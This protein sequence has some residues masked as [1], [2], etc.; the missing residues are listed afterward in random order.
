MTRAEQPRSE[1]DGSR[2]D[3]DAE[4][5]HVVNAARVLML[6]KDGPRDDYYRQTKEHAWNV[7]RDALKALDRR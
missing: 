5:D 6:L 4:R 3:R 7:L 1:W 2:P